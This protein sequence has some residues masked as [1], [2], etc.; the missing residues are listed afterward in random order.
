M[1]Q[2]PRQSGA[3]TTSAGTK[4]TPAGVCSQTAGPGSFRLGHALGIVLCERVRGGSTEAR[5][6]RSDIRRGTPP[7]HA[8]RCLLEFNSG[9][10][11]HSCLD[12]S[13]YRRAWI[14]FCR[15]IFLGS[16]GASYRSLRLD[17]RSFDTGGVICF[18]GKVAA[19]GGLTARS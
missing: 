17:K 5:W 19:E 7:V 3:M 4:E 14:D 11:A 12:V 1:G 9:S 13:G 18:S 15:L 10:A 16:P 8:F 6:A 2:G